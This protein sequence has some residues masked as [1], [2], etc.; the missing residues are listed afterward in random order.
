MMEP[1]FQFDNVVY[2]YGG[3]DAQPAA[4]NGISFEIPRAPGRR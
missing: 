2:R 4:L 3:S 1:M